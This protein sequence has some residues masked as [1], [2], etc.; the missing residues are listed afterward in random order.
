MAF[1]ASSFGDLYQ[2][3][4]SVE[5]NWSGNGSDMGHYG[6]IHCNFS[7]ITSSILME[8]TVSEGGWTDEKFHVSWSDDVEGTVEGG[9]TK[10]AKAMFCAGD[11][12][13]LHI[14]DGG[15]WQPPTNPAEFGADISINY[16]AIQQE[17]VLRDITFSE[18]VAPVGGK[19]RAKVVADTCDD[20]EPEVN[21]SVSG[22]ADC[23]ISEDGWIEAG[24]EEGTLTVRA[25]L[26]SDTSIYVE[27]TIEVKCVCMSGDCESLGSFSSSMGSIN[28]LF[29]LGTASGGE[30][31]GYLHLK[32]EEPSLYWSSPAGLTYNMVRDDVIVLR[33]N[34]AMLRQLK[35]PEGLVDLVVADDYL[36]YINYYTNVFTATN[37]AGFYITNSAES[38]VSYR[39]ENPVRLPG[40]TYIT[41][42]L[43]VQ[44]QG[45]SAVT[46]KYSKTSSG[47]SWTLSQANGLRIETLS[48]SKS[49][50]LRIETQTVA[51][52]SGIIASQI[53]SVYQ[54]NT[55]WGDILQSRTVDPLGMALCTSNTYDMTKGL[56][57][58]QT[59]PDGGWKEWT[60]DASGRIT[61]ERSPW[62]TNSMKIVTNVFAATGPRLEMPR[63]V[64]EYVDGNEVRYTEYSYSTNGAGET[65]EVISEHGEFGITLTTTNIYLD[66][67]GTGFSAGKLVFA[68]YPNGQTVTTAFETG[69]VAV[70]DYPSGSYTFTTNGGNAIRET[71]THGTKAAPSGVAY[72]TLREV[73]IY[74]SLGRLVSE[75]RQVFDGSGYSVMDWR[76]FEFDAFGHVVKTYNSDGTYSA[77]GWS[78]CCGKEWDEERTGLRTLYTYD[79]LKRVLSETR[80]GITRTF[81][82]DAE[83]RVLQ[84]VQSA[85]SFALTNRYQ[86]NRAGQMTNQVDQTGL[87]ATWT[88][89]QGGLLVTKTLPGGGT[90]ITENLSDGKAKSVT[91]TAAA[92]VYYTYEADASGKQ[93]TYAYYSEVE[94]AYW[95]ARAAD[96]LGRESVVREPASGATTNHY[97]TRGLLVRTVRPLQADM[98]YEYNDRGDLSAQGVDANNNGTLDR[99]S[100]DRI[101]ESERFYEVESTNVWETERTIV[102]PI[103]NSSQAVTN[104]VVRQRRNGWSGGLVSARES[105]DVYGQT[106]RMLGFVT[107]S[108][109]GEIRTVSYPDSNRE[110]R[111]EYANGRLILSVSR[112]GVTN[113]FQYD[114][115][116]RKTAEINTEFGTTAITYNHLGQVQQVTDPSG[117]I[118]GYGYD[119]ATGRLIAQTNAM[120]YVEYSAYNLRGNLT[121]RWGNAVYPTAYTFDEMGRMTAMTLWRDDA[122]SGDATRWHYDPATGLLTN[123]VYADGQGPTYAYTAA[124][125]L[126]SRTWAR[127]VSTLYA[128]DSLGQVTNINYSDATPDV[129]LTFDRMGRVKTATDAT[130]TRTNVY[131]VQGAILTEG[132]ALGTLLNHTVDAFGRSSGL[133]LGNEYALGYVYNSAGQ[134][135]S[136]TAAVAS[137]TS[138]VEY[139]YVPNS[140]RLSQHSITRQGS[141]SS[142][143]TTR[144]YE[145]N[146]N[147]VLQHKNA[148]GAETVSQF[149]YQNNA[150]GQRTRMTMSGAVMPGGLA[151]SYWE[152]SYDSRGQVTG[153]MRR[154]EDGSAVQLSH[155][156]AYDDIGNRVVVSESGRTNAYQANQLN[157]YTQRTVQG[158][159]NLRGNADPEATVTLNNSPVDRRGSYWSTERYFTN[160]AADVWAELSA[161]GVLL[162][163]ATNGE[164]IVA[165]DTGHV[166]LARTPEAFAYDADG[167]LTQDARFLY[168][169]DSENRLVVAETRS[170]LQSATPRVRLAFTYDNQ[171]RRVRKTV[172]SGFIGGAY[173]TTSVITFVWNDWLQI[174][175][176]CASSTSF[177]LWGLD[178]SG[179][180]QGAGG[181]GGLLATV[182]SGATYFVS[183][184]ANGNVTEYVDT[185]GTVVAHWEYDVFGN[186]LVL[187]GA[188]RDD[189]SHWFSSKP[190]DEETGAYDFGFRLYQPSQAR[191]MSRDPITERG[192]LN[193]Y[194]FVG[195]NPI[196]R[197]DRLGL[198]SFDQNIKW[199]YEVVYR[200]I[201][202]LGLGDIG[203]WLGTGSG[204][205]VSISLSGSAAKRRK[206]CWEAATLIVYAEPTKNSSFSKVEDS[207]DPARLWQYDEYYKTYSLRYQPFV[208][209][210]YPGS[211]VAEKL[212]NADQYVPGFGPNDGG[213][214]IY[215]TF[216][217]QGNLMPYKSVKI[218]VKREV[219][220]YVDGSGNEILPVL[221]FN[222]EDKLGEALK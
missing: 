7:S 118:T 15:T 40:T 78:L 161:I 122:G 216:T 106:T 183:E 135:A 60:F 215:R 130:G 214:Y 92:P 54:T 185:N 49:A 70:L 46:T 101:S 12:P 39:V 169:W 85:G 115:L 131:S 184:D 43:V 100:M 202:P 139:A 93:W 8:V 201:G 155:G 87:Q 160:T 129:S 170:N 31:A 165:V 152:Y 80:G 164:D 182:Q 74:D 94:G 140:A 65:T 116:G 44:L 61:S 25:T 222:L 203:S 149:D 205:A 127:G 66:R 10:V 156:F 192:G 105:V 99:A 29:G 188:K 125:Q 110:S 48:I 102:Y 181:V 218:T 117:A 113:G 175:D 20:S 173:S 119:P 77:S 1:V 19:C 144:A 67:N 132:T 197:F 153:A 79:G 104:S 157:Q 158:W 47:N 96:K 136:I 26:A 210:E 108:T 23:T 30:S 28:V 69:T 89:Q 187:T 14:Y 45:N 199:R 145:T 37:E 189:F 196:S 34:F 141:G 213:G 63:T 172:E 193:L 177:K 64:R 171:G 84:E 143:V 195:N 75:E 2:V 176:V 128:Q 123:K 91:G 72:K 221:T 13:T 174:A 24:T 168:E 134:F 68:S 178:L 109:T 146:R 21:W 88:Y 11:T 159:V 83:G 209:L 16:S 166:F 179:T 200:N 35:L 3:G 204:N 120:G 55:V 90:E 206:P 208:T 36:Y 186:A 194:S 62:G 82:Y 71:T 17:V 190:L 86:Y 6:A 97:D 51:D 41:N 38:V 150:L 9:R 58:R 191:F 198:A 163:G 33:D 32:Q 107:R 137:V 207:S 138:V 103:D 151:G 133:R 52:A 56:I 142:L 57:T 42:L 219:L 50:G 27:D 148:Y 5:G 180:M 114:D 4:Y 121:N 147:L 22:V 76:M 220:V 98:L 126:A 154:F 212:W 111:E 211:V 95:T 162:G 81:Q 217:R 167:N 59:Y 124:G 18:D 112:W 53:E 73:R